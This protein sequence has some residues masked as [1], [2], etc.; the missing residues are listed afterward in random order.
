[1]SKSL[2]LQEMAA[3]TTYGAINHAM[4]SLDVS[5]CEQF[6]AIDEPFVNRLQR[7]TKLYPAVKPLLTAISV[8]PVLPQSWRAGLALF[9]A[10]VDAITASPE[11]DPEFK[12]GKD[13]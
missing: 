11:A 4:R 7:L 10:T 12:A 5:E 2:Q 9:L 6:A 13:L 8:L 1:M 3:A